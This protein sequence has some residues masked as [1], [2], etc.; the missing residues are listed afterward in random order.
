MDLTGTYLEIART[1]SRFSQWS[2]REVTRSSTEQCSPAEEGAGT[3][4]RLLRGNITKTRCL[5]ETV[6]DTEK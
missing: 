3:L 4:K 5:K 1:V 6:K 2:T